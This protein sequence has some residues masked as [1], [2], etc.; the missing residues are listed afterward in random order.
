MIHDM[1]RS[2]TKWFDN[3]SSWLEDGATLIKGFFV[4]LAMVF[5]AVLFILFNLISL[6]LLA[7]L[8]IV[9][10]GN[11]KLKDKISSYK[12]DK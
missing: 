11:N 3:N 5:V 9:E 8:G 6:G 1:K 12:K 7:F 4:L 2:I 10:R